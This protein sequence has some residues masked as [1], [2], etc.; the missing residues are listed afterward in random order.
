[1]NQNLD[2]HIPLFLPHQKPM[3]MVDT[4]ESISEK[5]VCTRFTIHPDNLF[6]QNG[7]FQES[8]LIENAAQTSSCISAITY[9]QTV[10]QRV[11]L[12]GF[13]SAIKKLEILALPPVHS[14]I[15]TEAEL[16][17]FFHSDNHSLFQIACTIFHQKQLLLQ[18]NLTLFLEKVVP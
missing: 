3:L 14:A 9:Y 7:L 16:L 4:L 1:M 15:T 12:I 5:K 18:S 2:I 13:I 6:V 8:G 17:H 10:N 11:P